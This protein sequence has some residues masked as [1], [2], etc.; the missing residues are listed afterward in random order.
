[1]ADY[2]GAPVAHVTLPHFVQYHAY[3]TAYARDP[4]YAA[5]VRAEHATCD[6]AR[7]TVLD[8]LVAGVWAVNRV[9]YTVTRRLLARALASRAAVVPILHELG[10][11][12][13][14]RVRVDP[15][16]ARGPCAVTGTPACVF[17]WHLR[18]G[19]ETERDDSECR[20][21]AVRSDVGE[22]LVNY[23]ILHWYLQYHRAWHCGA[24]PLDTAVAADVAHAHA[25]F[26]YLCRTVACTTRSR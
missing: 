18:V 13:H 7:R 1:M 8:A 14:L 26:Q 20:K 3:A 9:R 17:R 4:T 23:H 22:V 21:W 19:E 11:S 25:T 15:A 24:T 2:A 6:P 16:G 10:A 5:R 12:S